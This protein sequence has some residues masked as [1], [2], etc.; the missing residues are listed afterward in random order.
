MNGGR[1][2]FPDGHADTWDEMDK[3]IFGDFAN[4]ERLK[5]LSTDPLLVSALAADDSFPDQSELILPHSIFTED[6]SGSKRK[7]RRLLGEDHRYSAFK[8]KQFYKDL[9]TERDRFSYESPLKQ[10]LNSPL[11][12]R[13]EER[14]ELHLREMPRVSMMSTG[15]QK[16]YIRLKAKLGK[17]KEHDE[18]K[19]KL[20][21]VL[22]RVVQKEQ[23][24]YVSFCL[25]QAK[26]V[27]TIDYEAVLPGLI[28][29]IERAL[30]HRQHSVPADYDALYHLHSAIDFDVPFKKEIVLQ[31]EMLLL[32]LGQ[33]PYTDMS[34]NFYHGASLEEFGRNLEFLL[35]SNDQLGHRSKEQNGPCVYKTPVSCDPNALHF[36]AETEA[37]IVTCSSVMELLT[38]VHPYSLHNSAT[39]RDIPV[40]VKLMQQTDGTTKKVVFLDKALPPL[41]M[42]LYDKKIWACRRA[43]RELFASWDVNVY[44]FDDSNDG[45]RSN[46]AASNDNTICD[47]VEMQDEDSESECFP[48]PPPPNQN[49]TY[50]LYSLCSSDGE[51]RKINLVVRSSYH[52]YEMKNGRDKPSFLHLSVKLEHQPE[53]GAQCTTISEIS[54][55][56][57]A[58]KLRKGAALA[59]VR[60][61]AK[62]LKVIQVEKKSMKAVQQECRVRGM[63]IEGRAASLHHTFSK[64]S[65]LEPGSY[66]LQLIPIEGLARLLEHDTSGTNLRGGSY[67]N[68]HLHFRRAN[69]L[70]GPMSHVPYSLIDP[71]VATPYHTRNERIPATFL[72]KC[73]VAKTPPAESLPGTSYQTVPTLADM[74]VEPDQDADLDVSDSESLV[75]W[76]ADTETRSIAKQLEEELVEDK[77]EKQGTFL[78]PNREDPDI[79]RIIMEMQVQSPMSA[80]C[81]TKAGS[82]VAPSFIA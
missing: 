73:E 34:S 55:E 53:Y 63:S 26:Y 23:R 46:V 66:L 65:K 43:V 42:T 28:T 58:L 68:L 62:T 19:N 76:M 44:R 81:S 39:R 45:G 25:R 22:H 30:F 47:D 48:L 31:P 64:L 61:D 50:G 7:G 67:F 75:E 9:Q 20:F 41:E 56:W 10:H 57:M 13:D 51:G 12:S 29:Y 80:L 82:S 14:H 15:K 11:D 71:L 3:I 32:A 77:S 37:E 69:H 2:S 33:V 54:R 35:P 59:R 17:T 21:K 78:M 70:I 4:K 40:M 79:M 27:K 6:Q 8:Y 24:D 38:D 1:L 16:M 72:P 60:V 52:A 5:Q 49:V 74:E 36:A 18:E